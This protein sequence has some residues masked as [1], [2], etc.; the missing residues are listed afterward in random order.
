MER[1][2]IRRK[3]LMPCL[4][5]GVFL[6]GCGASASKNEQQTNEV[7]DHEQNATSAPTATEMKKSD[8][9]KKKETAK[10]TTTYKDNI[11][12]DGTKQ[13]M[14]IC[15]NKKDITDTKISINNKQVVLK[16]VSIGTGYAHPTV[17][18]ADVTGDGKKEMIM[19]LRG[20]ASGSA[21][22]IQ[23]FRKSDGVWTEIPTPDTLWRDDDISVSY[24]AGKVEI[25][26]LGNDKTYTITHKGKDSETPLVG[27]RTCK[28][29]NDMLLVQDVIGWNT[30]NNKI[31]LVT[32]K[33]QYDKKSD[34]FIDHSTY[35]R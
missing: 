24:H 26:V 20:G 13:K 4:L 19:A 30:A 22:D 23:V 9:T 10:Y 25:S 1:K 34:S 29:K 15:Q 28:Q 27:I 2:M 21:S 16:R 8:A 7:A 35:V 17:S 31:G 11:L 32:Q 33:L 12:V 3:I 14:I 5:A 18:M 6:T